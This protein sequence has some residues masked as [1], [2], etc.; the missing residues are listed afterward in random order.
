MLM[1]FVGILVVKRFVENYS[2]YYWDEFPLSASII[3]TG[4][5]MIETYYTLEN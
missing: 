2:I 5:A 4:I 1:V 3:Y